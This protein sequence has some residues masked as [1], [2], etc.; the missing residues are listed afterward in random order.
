MSEGIMRTNY[1]LSQALYEVAAKLEKRNDE[2]PI[3]FKKIKVDLQ[4]AMLK[5][6]LFFLGE[7]GEGKS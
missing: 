5:A 2:G 7:E 1:E 6:K 4:I 3:E